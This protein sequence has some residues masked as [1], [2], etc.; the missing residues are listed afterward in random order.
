MLQA[1]LF[2][3]P[4]DPAA[5]LVEDQYLL[6]EQMMVAPLFDNKGGRHV[7][8]PAGKWVDYQTRKIFEGSQ[9]HYIEAGA[10]PGIILVKSG[11][12]IPHIKPALS[13][14]DMNWDEIELKAFSSGDVTAVTDFCFPETGTLV[15]LEAAYKDGSWKLT[16]KGNYIGKTRFTINAF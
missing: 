12:L 15:R 13:T 1:L 5:W 11:S 16:E 8:L 3:Y 9:W 4:G 14:D 7:Y 10:L 6:G 2:Q